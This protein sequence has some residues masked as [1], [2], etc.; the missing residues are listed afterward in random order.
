MPGLVP[1]IHVFKTA[2]HKGR[3]MTGTSS[4][5]T[6]FALLSEHDDIKM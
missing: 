6:R 1:G 5:K 4:A 2:P 3:G